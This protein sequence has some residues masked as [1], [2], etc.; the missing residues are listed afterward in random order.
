MKYKLDEIV[1]EFIIES[2]GASQVDNRFARLYQIAI[3]GMRE[4][5]S[6]NK[7]K[8]TV[9]KLELRD[10][11]TASLPADYIDYYRIGVCV[12]NEILAFAENPRPCPIDLNLDDCGQIKRRSSVSDEK[13]DSDVFYY[14]PSVYES[15]NKDGQFVGRQ[16]GIRGGKPV[17]GRFQINEDQ[18]YV[19][20]ETDFVN[21]FLDD[22]HRSVVIEYATLLPKDG[23]G[24][25]MV[26]PY[27]T[28]AIKAWMWWKYIQRQR[29]YTL[30]DKEDARLEYGRQKK[31][32][33]KRLNAMTI[34]DLVGAVRRGYGGAPGI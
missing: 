12:G 18:G 27:E 24:N 23:D 11:S 25:I 31:K 10:N 4:I 29:S 32:A 17:F 22:E 15:F 16:F 30:G 6:D 5:H 33:R 19:Y 28:E 34:E 21:Q 1:R 26:H 9:A 20:I 13:R 2:F 3:S 14:Y 7:L 8:P